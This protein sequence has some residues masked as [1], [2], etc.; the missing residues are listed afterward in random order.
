LQGGKQNSLARKERR[1][2]ERQKLKLLRS[3][4]WIQILKSH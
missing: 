4:K 2:N 3:K 1:K